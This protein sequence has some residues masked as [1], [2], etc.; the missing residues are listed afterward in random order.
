MKILV[1]ED[2]FEL[3]SSIKQF[4]ESEGYNV[5][6]ASTYNQAMDKVLVYEYSCILLDIN[7][8]GGNGLDI[9]KEI[10]KEKIKASIIIISAR[11]SLDDKIVGLDLGSMI[12]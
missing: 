11:D 3:M 7:L 6:V 2:E 10:K 9:L 12:I 5:E 4:L 1:V 8:P